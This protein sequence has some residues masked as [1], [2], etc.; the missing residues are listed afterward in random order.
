MIWPKRSYPSFVFYYRLV[1]NSLN[2]YLV[3]FKSCK[4]LSYSCKTK[5]VL[6]HM[7]DVYK[8]PSWI[9]LRTKPLQIC[10][11][12][13]PLWTLNKERIR[14]LFE[15]FDE[16]DVFIKWNNFSSQSFNKGASA[17][18]L[19]VFILATYYFGRRLFFYSRVCI[20]SFLISWIHVFIILS[21]FIQKAATDTFLPKILNL[22][23]MMLL[24]ALGIADKKRR[25]FFLKNY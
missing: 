19:T 23:M 16:L 22:S 11:R 2:Y 25:N 8:I 24:K 6:H 21:K 18:L 17:K 7:D 5:L 12:P 14:Y 4:L 20:L 10:R 15:C 13:F 1:A 3:L 9:T